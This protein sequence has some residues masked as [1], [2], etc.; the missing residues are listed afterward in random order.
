MIP[1]QVRPGSSRHT[2]LRKDGS[3]NGSVTAQRLR[4]T[5]EVTLSFSPETVDEYDL[6]AG[7][8]ELDP[9]TVQ[10]AEDESGETDESIETGESADP[11]ADD[12][13]DTDDGLSLFGV[14]VVTI[15]GVL[16]GIFL[17]RWRKNEE[18]E[19]EESPP[20]K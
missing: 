4:V 20:P 2:M 9:L 11:N 15:C 14:G 16:V 10:A 8:I 19:I 13:D 7:G 5:E 3:I 12:T 18:D 1:N 17:L 6:A